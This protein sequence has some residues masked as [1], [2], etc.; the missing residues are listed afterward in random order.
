MI[1]AFFPPMRMKARKL[2]SA[3]G[4][5]RFYNKLTKLVHEPTIFPLSC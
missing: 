2:Q 3:K 5:G 4:A 1:W